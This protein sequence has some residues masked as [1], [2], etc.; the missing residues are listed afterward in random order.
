MDPSN[1]EAIPASLRRQEETGDCL[2]IRDL[3]KEFGTKVA[4]E[5]TNINIYDG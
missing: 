1:F 5:N 3:R 2:K 4:V